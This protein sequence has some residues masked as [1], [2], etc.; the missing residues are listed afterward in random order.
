MEKRS[1]R[2]FK[3]LLRQ[4]HVGPTEKYFKSN[5]FNQ[6]FFVENTF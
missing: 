2:F 3:E 4:T 1:F 6:Q 5:P